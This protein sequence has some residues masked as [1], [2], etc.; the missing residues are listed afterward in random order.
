MMRE[1]RRIFCTRAD[2]SSPGYVGATRTPPTVVNLFIDDQQEQ[3][4][5]LIETSEDQNVL[6]TYH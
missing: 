6:V 5:I 1:L 3:I 2:V 4:H